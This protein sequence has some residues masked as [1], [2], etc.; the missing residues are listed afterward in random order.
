MAKAWSPHDRD[1]LH[2]FR[3]FRIVTEKIHRKRTERTMSLDWPMQGDEQAGDE[4]V[5]YADVYDVLYGSREVDEEF[6][7]DCAR[8]VLGSKGELLEIGCGTGRLSQRLLREGYELTCVDASGH[9]LAQAKRALARYEG[10]V[11]I[12]QEDARTLSLGRRFRLAL[13]PFAVVAHLLSNEDRYRAYRNVF[14]HLEPGGVFIFDDMPN[15][16]AK[17]ADGGALEER[18]SGRCP[19]T[20]KPVRLLCNWVDVAD[21]PYSLRYDFIDW[22][23]GERILK[24]KV[25]RAVFRNIA[26]DEEI[27]ILRDAGF[28]SIE[29]LGGF[30][31]RPLD[32]ARPL[33]NERLIVFARRST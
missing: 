21:Q 4:Y 6:Y 8:S 33:S 9:M 31:G 32:R 25:I 3:E 14:E 11:R 23:D 17:P 22:L 15:W 20:G 24:R 26:V 28:G 1:G 16:M 2:R 13:A 27:A 7:V 12:V 10:R 5:K 18:A 19:T 30:D 29:L